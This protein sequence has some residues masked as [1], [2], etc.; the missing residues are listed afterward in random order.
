LKSLTLRLQK[1]IIHRKEENIEKFKLKTAQKK[2]PKKNKNP[3]KCLTLLPQKKII[4]KKF[5]IYLYKKIEIEI[6]I[7]I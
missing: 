6:I 3:L 1:K 7:I 5:F 4:H 2:N